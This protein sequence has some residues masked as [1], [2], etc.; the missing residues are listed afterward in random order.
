MESY[1]L[2]KCSAGNI[3]IF[4]LI[5]KVPESRDD[6]AKHLDLTGALFATLGLGGITYGFLEAS[7]SSFSNLRIEAALIIGVISIII[8]IFVEKRE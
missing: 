3:T 6:S 5:L 2:Y 4:I 1:I 8:F 7:E